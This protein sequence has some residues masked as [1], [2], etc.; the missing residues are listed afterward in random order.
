MF[1]YALAYASGLVKNAGVRIGDAAFIAR[2]VFELTDAERT[3]ILT[4]LR[5][6]Q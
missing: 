1:S 4:A 3:E 6:K 5:A 2:N